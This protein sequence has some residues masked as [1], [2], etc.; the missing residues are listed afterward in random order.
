M[1]PKPSHCADCPL[2]GNA[3]GF[4]NLEGTGESGLLVLAEALGEHEEDDGLP[5]RP[6]APAGSIFQRA[7]RESRTRRNDLLITNIVRCR[8]P[9][10][11]LVGAEYERAA[12]DHCQHY[13]D[14][15]IAQYQPSAILALGGTPLAE[16]TNFRGILT[17]RGFILPSRYGIPLIA[18]YHPALLA[19]GALGTLFGVF[20]RDVALAMQ[21][22][23]DGPPKLLETQYELQPTLERVTAYYHYLRDNPAL[24]AAYDVETASILGEA[25]SDDWRLKRIVQIQFSHRAGYAIVLPYHG[26]FR[27]LSHQILALSNPKWGWNSRASDDLALAGD[28]CRIGGERHDL[29]NA[30]QHHH[31][32]FAGQQKDAGGEADKGIVARL[33]GLQACASFYCPEVGPWKHLS[34]DPAN[35]QLYGAWDADITRRCGDGIFASL[36]KQGLMEGYRKH[37]YELRKVLDDMGQR[38]L[39]IDRTKQAEVRVYAG[40]ELD[41]MR[42]EIQEM[43]PPQLRGVHPANGYKT[44]KS[45]VKVVGDG[46][47][48]IPIADLIANYDADSPPLLEYAQFHGHLVQELFPVLPKVVVDRTQ[49]VQ[50]EKRWCAR[51]LFNVGSSDQLLRYIRHMGYRVPKRLDDP[52]KDTTGKDELAKLA[53]ETGDELLLLTDR[54][55]KFAKL[56]GSYVGKVLKDGTVVGD[57]VPGDDGR[58]HPEFRWGTGSG[59]LTCVSPNAQQFPE[60]GPLA[61]RAKEMIVAEPGHTFVKVDMRGFHARMIG[62]LA[63]DEAYYKLADFDV[64]SFITA[65]YLR[66]PDAPYLLEMSD[67]ELR[68]YLATVKSAHEYVRNF[69]V[70]RVVHG[71]QFGM[72]VNKLYNMHGPDLN[73]SV[74]T[75]VEQVGYAKWER[76]TDEQRLKAIER[77]GRAEA[78]K[79]LTL[80]RDLFP[81]TFDSARYS[82]F[83]A[84]IARRIREETPCYLKSPFGHIR[85]FWDWDKEKSTAYLPSNCSHCH[86]QYGLLVLDSLGALDRYQLSNFTHDAVWYHSPTALVGECLETTKRVFERKSD[87]LF[88]R[89]GAFQCNSDAEVG[90]DL[91]HMEAHN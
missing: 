5:L 11:E 16:L 17:Y 18:T 53:K 40:G 79:L 7:L 76:M 28:G 43:V 34:G 2:V 61:K 72:G 60:H 56:A 22:A 31:P 3:M 38:G 86:I 68:A 55:R 36:K 10:N 91:A 51:K 9:G 54:Y 64:H 27:L 63:E 30:W 14:H 87:V 8:P 46:D 52:T 84:Q 21:V 90:Y 39:P 74:Q 73:P 69:K 80:L 35:I 47:D 81:A 89:W 71:S 57:W 82:S 25:E 4:S 75:V 59:Q 70:K 48:K 44:T 19:R 15:A 1:L 26:E 24:A 29:M 37:K 65:H 88:N 67:S 13:L 58:V 12:I 42:S 23:R 33:M 78:Q 66:L 41:R 50:M 6:Q 62:F 45:K 83:P 77:A 32:D 85:W 20:K 49:P